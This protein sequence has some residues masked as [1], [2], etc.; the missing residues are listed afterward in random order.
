MKSRFPGKLSKARKN[1]GYTQKDIEKILNIKQSALASYE[2]GRSRP[3]Y[4]NLVRLADLYN[5]SCDWLLDSK[6]ALAQEKEEMERISCFSALQIC[7][8]N[9]PALLYKKSA[10]F[11][12]FLSEARVLFYY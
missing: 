1:A 8:A 5:V 11:F 3:T 10:L 12:G 9:S 2:S 4:E 6:I 7:A